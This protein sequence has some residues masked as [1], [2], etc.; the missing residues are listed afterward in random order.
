MII[1]IIIHKMLTVFTGF[2][3]LLQQVCK[4]KMLFFAGMYRYLHDVHFILKETWCV[5]VKEEAASKVTVILP[6]VHKRD[7]ANLGC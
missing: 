4:W 5:G 3:Q 6:A 7:Y 1:I 2:L